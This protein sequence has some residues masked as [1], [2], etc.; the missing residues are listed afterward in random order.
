MRAFLTMERRLQDLET[1]LANSSRYGVVTDVKFDDDKKRWYAKMQDG[2]GDD[3]TFKS[4]WLPW[5]SFSHGTVG[6]SQ[7]PRKGQKVTYSAP[8]GQPEL[9]YVEPHHN[10]PDNPSPDGKQDEIHRVVETAPD[11][12]GDKYEHWKHETD[13]GYHIVVRKKEQQAQAAAAPAGDEKE[14]EGKAKRTRKMPEIGEEGAEGAVQI[15]TTK[16][17]VLITVGGG[18]KIYAQGDKVTI[19]RGS[20][21][22]T[23]TDDTITHKTKTFKVESDAFE[24]AT[25]SVKWSKT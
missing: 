14:A 23:M 7:P 24:V 16:D 4:N 25:K 13:Q 6:V 10:D 12:E 15:K 21:V 19:K 1:R 9:A 20:S 3:T 5:K 22:T 11:K 17:G 18:T 2:E 8:G